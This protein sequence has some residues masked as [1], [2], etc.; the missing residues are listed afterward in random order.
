M[1]IADWHERFPEA[2]LTMTAQFWK[3]DRATVPE[4]VKAPEESM[5]PTWVKE[6]SWKETRDEPSEESR[7]SSML[8]QSAAVARHSRTELSKSEAKQDLRR[9][10]DIVI[11]AQ[12]PGPEASRT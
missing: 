2:S 5:N 10:S 9:T 3:A 1:S 12:S 4:M 11:G 7:M 6:E 8:S